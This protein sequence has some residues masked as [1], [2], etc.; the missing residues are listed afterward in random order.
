[1]DR[2]TFEGI[3]SSFHRQ[4]C[5]SP[6]DLCLMTLPEMVDFPNRIINFG[7]ISRMAT[8]VPS[9]VAFI[10]MKS[11]PDT[12][13]ESN[14]IQVNLCQKLLFLHQLTN[15]M[16]TDCL[17]NYKFNTWKI[18][19]SEHGE[20]ILCTEIVFNIQNHICTQHILPMF[21]KNM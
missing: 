10:R 3:F 20:N 5:T 1:M 18:P 15:N 6:C 21:W 16:M 8:K 17:L 2:A 4:I 13:L 12:I 14:M 9:R 19:S 11:H 7:S